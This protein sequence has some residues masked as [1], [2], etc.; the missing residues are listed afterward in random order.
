MEEMGLG[1]NLDPLYSFTYK[2]D[3]GNGLCEHEIDHVLIGYSD[4][5]PNTNPKEVGAYKFDP[6]Q[7]IIDDLNT[8]PETYTTW[9]HVAFPILLEKLN[10][11]V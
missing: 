4:D 2:S 11:E 1:C 8:L 7:R 6:L 9:F 10:K 5:E 3:V